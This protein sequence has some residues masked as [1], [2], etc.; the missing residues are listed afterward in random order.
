MASIANAT[1]GYNYM[2]LI[3]GDGTPYDILYNLVNGHKLIYP[4]LV[5]VLFL[6]YIAAFYGIYIL[7]SKRLDKKKAMAESA[8]QYEDFK[9]PENEAQTQQ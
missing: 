5:I 4:M 8:S 9:N 6:I 7:I 1:V 3:R 2:F